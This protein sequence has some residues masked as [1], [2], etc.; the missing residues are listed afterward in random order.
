MSTVVPLVADAAGRPYAVSDVMSDL[1]DVAARTLVKGGRL[2]YII[3]S[4]ADFDPN[5]DLP[6]HP[7]LKPLYSCFQPLSSDLGRRVVAMEKEVEYDASRRQEYLASTWKNDL[8]AEKVAN[9]R[10]KLIEAAKGKPRY[11]ERA[12]ARKQKRKEHREAK[13]RAKV[14]LRV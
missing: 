5:E 11:E 4:F 10:S 12:A 14:M 9:I 13:K 8:S 1:L 3:P 6:R 2:V 7:C